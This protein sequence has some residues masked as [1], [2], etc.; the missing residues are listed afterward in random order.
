M[1]GTIGF[2]LRSPRGGF[3]MSVITAMMTVVLSSGNSTPEKERLSLIRGFLLGRTLR[4][5]WCLQMYFD[6]RSDENE[7]CGIGGMK[8][9]NK[10]ALTHFLIFVFS[11]LVTVFQQL[12]SNYSLHLISHFNS[13]SPSSAFCRPLSFHLYGLST[14]LPCLRPI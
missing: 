12:S 4:P 14:L 3:G 10:T 9:R 13:P 1:L 5:Q 11:F 8:A 7:Q 2:W 6:G